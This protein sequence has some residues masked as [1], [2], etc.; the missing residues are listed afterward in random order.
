MIYPDEGEPSKSVISAI[1][2]LGDLVIIAYFAVNVF[3]LHKEEKLLAA[4]S[5]RDEMLLFMRIGM[6]FSPVYLI[7]RAVKIDKKWAYAV[8]GTLSAIYWWW[9]WIFD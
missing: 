8:V 2:T 3:F 9:G 4:A 5:R 6:F 1:G 7:A